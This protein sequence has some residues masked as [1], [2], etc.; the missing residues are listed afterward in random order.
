MTPIPNAQ[1]N[2]DVAARPAYSALDPSRFA[3]VT[4]H[5]PRPWSEALD[6]YIAERGA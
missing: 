4:G 5:R 3:E 1:W 6:E 2:E